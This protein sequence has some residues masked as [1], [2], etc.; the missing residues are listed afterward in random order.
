MCFNPKQTIAIEYIT[1]SLELKTQ[2][3]NHNPKWTITILLIM[4]GK[5]QQFIKTPTYFPDVCVNLRLEAFLHMRI[6]C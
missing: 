5:V 3:G 1:L 6:E 2:L 4:K